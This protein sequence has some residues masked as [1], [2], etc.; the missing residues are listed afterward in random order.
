M[1][2]TCLIVKQKRKPKFK[3]RSYNRCNI[4]GRPNGYFR[5]FGLCRICLREK[6]HHGELPGVT[7][8]SW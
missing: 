1:A 6:A 5:F 8:S 7:K 4:C 2:K 3:V